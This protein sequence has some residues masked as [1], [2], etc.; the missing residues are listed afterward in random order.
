MVKNRSKPKAPKTPDCFAPSPVDSEVVVH[1]AFTVHFSYCLYK[2]AMRLRALLDRKLV[3]I[4][5]IAPHLGIL[6]FLDLEHE[7]SQIEIGRQ[8]GVDGATMVKLLDTLQKSKLVVRKPSPNDRRVN[9]I[10]L[11]ALGKKVLVDASKLRSEVEEEF[12]SR[13]PKEDREA[14]Q[15][16]MPKLLAGNL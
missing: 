5:L 13:L 1:P 6:R 14:L 9:Q 12:L 3:K 10:S 16:I 8:M 7:K 4:G 11:T 2:S 15:R